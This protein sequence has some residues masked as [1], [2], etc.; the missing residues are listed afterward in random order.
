[1][2]QRVNNPRLRAMVIPEF[3]TGEGLNPSNPICQLLDGL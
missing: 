3:Q 1:M 2:N